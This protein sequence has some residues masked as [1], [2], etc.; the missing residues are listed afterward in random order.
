VLP[1]RFKYIII[2]SERVEAV[3]Y[4]SIDDVC[5]RRLLKNSG[6]QVPVSETKRTGTQIPNEFGV[7]SAKAWL[8]QPER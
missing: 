5:I 7:I 1:D 3:R 4:C 6:K 8:C 2:S